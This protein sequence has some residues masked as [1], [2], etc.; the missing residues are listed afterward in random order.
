MR[1]SQTHPETILLSTTEDLYDLSMLEEMEDNEYLLEILG[2]LLD[3]SPKDI[4][5]LKE[6]LQAGKTDFVGKK[7]H[8]LKS[9]AGVIQAERLTGLLTEIENIGKAG[10]VTNE[11]S[12]LVDDAVFEYNRIERSLKLF[13][14][15]LK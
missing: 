4:K 9:S 11:L 2:V 6:A 10:S 12:S 8:K 3:E 7:A 15:R 1:N 13:V 5:E 14:L